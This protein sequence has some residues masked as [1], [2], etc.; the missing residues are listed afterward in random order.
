MRA[1]GL[2]KIWTTPLNFRRRAYAN[3]QCSLREKSMT[4]AGGRFHIYVIKNLRPP[5]LNSDI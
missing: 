3:N 1:I 5:C 2:T 4:Y